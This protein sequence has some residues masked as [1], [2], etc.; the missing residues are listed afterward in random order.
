MSLFFASVMLDTSFFVP[1]SDLGVG[2]KC[3]FYITGSGVMFVL[4][5]SMTRTEM[6]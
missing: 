4:D 6:Y 5:E 3:L 1:Q 2:V